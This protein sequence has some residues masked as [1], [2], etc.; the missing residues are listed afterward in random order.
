V[1]THPR[2]ARRRPG[3]R[4]ELVVGQLGEH[5]QANGF[6]HLGRQLV[7]R[8]LDAVDPGLARLDVCG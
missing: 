8:L 6:A 2:G 7:E 1:N 4:G 3:R 5:A